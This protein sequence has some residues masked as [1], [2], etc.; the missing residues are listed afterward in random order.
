MFV[1]VLILFFFV[2]I[3]FLFIEKKNVQILFI[4]FSF[5]F[6]SLSSS[7]TSWTSATNAS[8]AELRAAPNWRLWGRKPISWLQQRVC[9]LQQWNAT[10]VSWTVECQQQRISAARCRTNSC[11]L[12]C[13]SLP[14][15]DEWNCCR[16]WLWES[17]NSLLWHSRIP[18][19]WPRLSGPE[20]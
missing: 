4:Y 8:R 12:R 19:Q 7:C 15:S 9:R 5:T 3:Y 13:N 18:I 17:R 14:T 2:L 1:L 6:P 11:R 20:F 10:P 16:L